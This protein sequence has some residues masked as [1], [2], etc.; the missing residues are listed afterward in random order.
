MCTD[1][2]KTTAYGVGVLCGLMSRRVA[3]RCYAV[4]SV[5]FTPPHLSYCNSQRY[6]AARIRVS[7]ADHGG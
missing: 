3:C 5:I 6:I 1:Y 7:S 2:N 4:K